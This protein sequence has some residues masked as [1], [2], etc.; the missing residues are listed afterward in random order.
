MFGNEYFHNLERYRFENIISQIYFN[1][2]VTLLMP[3]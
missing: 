2:Y 3:S 1:Q